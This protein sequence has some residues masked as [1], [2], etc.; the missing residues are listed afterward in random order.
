MALSMIRLFLLLALVALPHQ[1]IAQSYPIKPLRMIVPMPPGGSTDIQGRWAAQ[2]ISTA[3]GQPVIVDNRP[4]AGGVPGTDTAAKAAPD[5]YTLLAGNAGP[6][7]VSPSIVAKMPYD[8]LRDLA[9]ISLLAKTAL[10]LCTY[11]GIPAKNLQEFVSL[12]KARDGKINYGTPGVGTIGHLGIEDL[13]ARAGIKLTHVPYK[14][15]AQYMIDLVNGT[16]DVALTT[17]PVALVKLGKVRVVGIT[18]L[19]RHPLLP[20]APTI[21]EQ[22]LKDYESV[23][24]NGILAPAGT[25]RAVVIRIHDVLAKA[26]ATPEARKSFLGRGDDPSGL[27]PEEFGVFLKAEVEKFEQVARASGIPKM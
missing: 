18:T 11:S 19:K 23:L 5:G 25:P 27:G 2:H 15:A 24:W 17:P 4:G 3:L 13:S 8:T 20:E 7:T 10:C 6:L 1:G 22:G 9:P 16:L 12:A 26:L 14:G 21:A